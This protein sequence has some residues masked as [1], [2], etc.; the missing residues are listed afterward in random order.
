MRT[1][2]HRVVC[3]S[4]LLVAVAFAAPAS[5]SSQRAPTLVLSSSVTH[6]RPA[7]T[8]VVVK[9]ATLGGHAFAEGKLAWF[10]ISAGALSTLWISRR[11]TVKGL[12]DATIS[13]GASWRSVADRSSG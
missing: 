11:A 5:G 12:E 1:M 7:S 2:R 10:P 9:D 3:A 13:I 6:P 8:V 4:A